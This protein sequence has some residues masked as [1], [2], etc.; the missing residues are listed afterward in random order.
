MN[1]IDLFFKP[2]KVA[3]I[4]ASRDPKSLAYQTFK[5]MIESGFEGAFFPVNPNADYVLGYKSYKSVLEIE[6]NIDL[7]V[8]TTPSRIVPFVLEECG[9]KGI[10]AVIIITAGFKEIGEEGEI[11]E[12]KIKEIGKK[13][14]IRIVGPNCLGVINTSQNVRLNTFFATPMPQRGKVSFVSQSGAICVSLLDHAREKGIG[15][16][17]ILS[18]GNK[19]DVDEIDALSYFKDDPETEIILLYIEGILRGEEFF[20]IARET[21]KKKPV[22]VL[23]VGRT[24]EG[25]RAVS[26]HT[27]AIA[28]IDEIY[29]ALFKKAGILRVYSLEEMLVKALALISQPL[30]KG[31]RVAIITNAGGTGIIATDECIKR[32]LRL[33]KIDRKTYEK[34][35]EKVPPYA[36]LGNPFDLIGDADAE[37]YEWVM[38]NLLKDKNVDAVISMMVP[39]KMIDMEEVAKRMAKY[40]KNNKKPLIPAFLGEK[41]VLK[42]VEILKR[43][44]VPFYT[45]PEDAINAVSGL[46]EYSELKKGIK[47]EKEIIFKVEKEKAKEIL[48]NSFKNEDGFLLPQDSLKILEFYGFKA[49]E[50][51]YAE[52]EKD[53]YKICKRINFPIVMKVVAD[54]VIHKMAGGGVIL[55]INSEKE[56]IEKFK[57]MKEKFLKEG[58]KGVIIQKMAKPGKE[59]IIGAK[60]TNFFPPLLMFGLGGIY[61]EIIKD[62]SFGIVPIFPREAIKMIKSIKG[63]NLLKGTSINKIKEIILRTSQM[64]KEIEEIEEIDLNPVFVYKKDA[65]V[66]DA[67]IKI[68]KEEK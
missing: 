1:V 65:V 17:K 27:G 57:K 9:K 47:E 61:V 24:P 55:N 44:N 3:I 21:T 31:N 18:I 30:P 60:R 68:K 20:K 51:E 22:I 35:K 59:I 6:D 16:S 25:A 67:R 32:G 4:G 29:E 34:L 49:V 12:E 52:N 19:V 37:R 10:R 36:S 50:W 28:G 45:F 8:I 42:P 33:A 63:F 2:K 43:E 26:S 64:V 7:A 39:Q 14:N 5:S 11:L 58:F 40:A 66:V 62:V 53:V 13:Y 48:D 46:Y 23:K 38:K 15:F 41:S 56:A 54:K